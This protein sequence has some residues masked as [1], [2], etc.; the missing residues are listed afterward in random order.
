VPHTSS[1]LGKAGAFF[2][3]V[4]G[5]I[6][7]IRALLLKRKPNL[8]FGA[9]FGTKLIIRKGSPASRASGPKN[10]QPQDKDFLAKRL[11]EDR[12]RMAVEVSEMKQDYIN[13]LC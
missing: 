7:V 4:P 11:E 3:E 13:H 9:F 8:L 12:Q 2:K 6:S 1:R 10:L 5:D